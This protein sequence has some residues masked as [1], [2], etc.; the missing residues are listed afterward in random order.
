MQ[1]AKFEP[2]EVD[3]ISVE[4]VFKSQTSWQ[5]PE[6]FG[7]LERTG[8]TITVLRLTLRPDGTLLECGSEGDNPQ[9]VSASICE[10]RL[11]EPIGAFFREM[12]PTYS[13]FRIANSWTPPMYKA[14]PAVRSWGDRLAYRRDE[15]IFNSDKQTFS[16]YTPQS[17]GHADLLPDMCGDAPKATKTEIRWKHPGIVLQEETAVFAVKRTQ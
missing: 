7:P 2:A 9:P 13:T 17:D 5:L 4:S 6:E 15:Q 1:R 11:R 12:A 8:P 16:C 3:G 14:R 10:D